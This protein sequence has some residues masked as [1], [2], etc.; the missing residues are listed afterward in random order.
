MIRNTHLL[1]NHIFDTLAQIKIK[2]HEEIHFLVGMYEN[3]IPQPLLRLKYKPDNKGDIIA[4]LVRIEDEG[5]Y[6]L[7]YHLRNTGS[8]TYDITIS[9]T[10][11]DE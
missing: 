11:S 9:A 4:S 2:P 10:W 3:A 8:G 6:S 7:V 1:P 5:D